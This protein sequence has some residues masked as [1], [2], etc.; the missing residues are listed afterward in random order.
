MHAFHAKGITGTVNGGHVVGIVNVGENQRE[1][2]LTEFEHVLQFCAS[3]GSWVLGHGRFPVS[4]TAR[5]GLEKKNDRGY[6]EPPDTR[7]FLY[8]F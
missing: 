2:R 3:S 1:I 8:R 4:E 7:G 6:P 5:S